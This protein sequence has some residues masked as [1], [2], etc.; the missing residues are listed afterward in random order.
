MRCNCPNCAQV[1]VQDRNFEGLNYCTNCRQLFFVPERKVP[2]W[3]W[4]VLTLMVVNL[5]RMCFFP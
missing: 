3:I 1:I 5:Q 4:G 2:G